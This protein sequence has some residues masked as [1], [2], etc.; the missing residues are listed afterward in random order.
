LLFL[1]NLCYVNAVIFYYYYYLISGA[2]ELWITL[3]IR[4]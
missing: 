4:V 1:V 2:F 3:Y